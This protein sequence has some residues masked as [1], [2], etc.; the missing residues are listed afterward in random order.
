MSKMEQVYYNLLCHWY[1]HRR[2]PPRMTE[3]ANLCRPRKSTT[4]I[5]SALISLESKKYVLRNDEGR[6]EVIA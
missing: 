2:E 6:F 3:L 1:K 5:R 4:A